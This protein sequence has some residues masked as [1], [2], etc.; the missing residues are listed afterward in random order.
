[1]N[2]NPSR[3]DKQRNFDEGT[4]EEYVFYQTWLSKI[5]SPE[6]GWG[7]IHNT[8]NG[9]YRIEGKYKLPDFFLNHADG[10]SFFLDFK[11]KVV[12]SYQHKPHVSL[13]E[14]FRS[15]YE[16]IGKQ[17]G[18]P[19]FVIWQSKTQQYADN[20]YVLEDISR[21]GNIVRKFDNAYGSDDGNWYRLDGLKQ[22]IDFRRV[23][24][25]SG[26]EKNSD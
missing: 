2:H 15:G 26:Q 11:C 8:E 1:M 10:R 22:I 9:Q 12:Y 23:K 19:V 14:S 17:A 24:N 5:Y 16:E 21:K 3:E 7:I 20:L 13:D 25:G 18:V 4:S 6:K